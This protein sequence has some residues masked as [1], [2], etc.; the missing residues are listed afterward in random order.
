MVKKGSILSRLADR[1]RT[2]PG[3]KVE[4]GGRGDV[5]D[6]AR[7]QVSRMERRDLPT[8]G[9]PAEARSTRKLSER[10]DAMV[11]LGGHFQELATLLRGVHT[12]MDGQLGRL[13]ET[14]TS[15]QQ[16]PALQNQQ[17]D[18]LRGMSGQLEKQNQLGEQIA[19]TLHGLPKLLT[20]VETA[21]Q[22]AAQSDE[23]TSATMREFQGTMDRIHLAMGRMVE[24]SE[25][26][27]KATQSLA[28]SREES[29]TQ[30]TAGIE[31]SQREA[32]QQLRA[33]ADESMQALRRS[34]EDQSNRLQRV[35]QDSAGLQKWMLVGLGVVALG[36]LATI[37]ALF[38]T[39]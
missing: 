5:R 7:A 35:V 39:R 2:G 17:M 10:E 32:V 21:L 20:S 29:V 8:A 37:V 16:L 30:L 27:A 19:Q 18:L 3:V 12:R 14:A 15:L 25:Q 9:A 34:N 1:F 22:R 28:K 24:H 23:R 26:Q 4:D 13:V 36:M 31:K 38:A 6:A 33:A 11:A